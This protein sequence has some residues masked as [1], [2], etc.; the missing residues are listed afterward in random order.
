MRYK[1]IITIL[2]AFLAGA[3]LYF[4]SQG[5]KDIQR[6]ETANII[7]NKIKEVNKLILIEGTFAEVYTYKQAENIFF[8]F[9]PV[10]KKV[11]ILVKAKAS[12]GYDLNKVDF[13]IDKEKQV[14]IIRNIPEE[15]IIIE[16]E[17]Q[18]YDI[19][20]STFYP[21]EAK[22]L[23]TINSRAVELIRKQVKQ[24]NLPQTAEKRLKEVLEGIIF[25]GQNLGW[26]VIQE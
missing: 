3:C 18:Y 12:V 10:E 21:L 22:D 11:L 16:P 25:T 13:L 14:V 20:Q 6:E 7:L 26:E 17:I 8:N 15:E 5:Q 24:S 2:I 23:T 1:L 19:Q 9:I 4:F